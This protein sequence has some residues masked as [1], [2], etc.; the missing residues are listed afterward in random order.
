MPKSQSIEDLQLEPVASASSRREGPPPQYLDLDKL[1]NADGIVA[2]IS[3][4]LSN[5][6]ITFALFK[7][8]ER[9]RRVERT[10]FI[11]ATLRDSYTSMVKLAFERID[12][13]NRDGAVMAKLQN[14]AISKL[15]AY[16]QEHARRVLQVTPPRGGKR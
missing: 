13:L 1:K 4:R 6:V 15:E 10:S 16:H 8:F 7:E 5:R 14:E 3:Q 2:I 11:A 9:D 12:E